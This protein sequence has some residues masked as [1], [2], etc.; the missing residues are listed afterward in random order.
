MFP[1]REPFRLVPR[2]CRR[3]TRAPGLSFRALFPVVPSALLP[4]FR[5]L[6]YRHSERSSTVIPNAA[7]NLTSRP[8]LISR[9]P[10]SAR[11]KAPTTSG[12]DETD[13]NGYEMGAAPGPD[14]S[15]SVS[16]VSPSSLMPA[17]QGIELG[18]WTEIPRLASLARNDHTRRVILR[19]W[20]DLRCHPE[21][22]ERP[23][24]S[25]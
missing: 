3:A 4:S 2:Q 9:W 21:G 24:V 10:T 6:P 1:S 22:A 15:V 14:P 16:S 8:I 11:Q 5:T 17:R 12:R 23:P 20:S 7:R 19:E 18:T 13:G 25:S